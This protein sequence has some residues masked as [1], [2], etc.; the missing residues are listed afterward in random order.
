MCTSRARK[1]GIGGCRVQ[2]PCSKR[3]VVRGESPGAFRGCRL[4]SAAAAGTPA[5]HDD[6]FSHYG[7][8]T[9]ATVESVETGLRG[10][11]PQAAG[12]PTCSALSTER[13]RRWRGKEGLRYGPSSRC[14]RVLPRA[15]RRQLSLKYKHSQQDQVVNSL[16]LLLGSS[17]VLMVGSLAGRYATPEMQ[18]VHDLTVELINA[19]G[20]GAVD[21]GL[22]PALKPGGISQGDDALR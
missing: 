9:P 16:I 2:G 15:T 13:V 21:V 11:S 20:D 6:K 5:A 10:T 18:S 4:F 7:V 1:G 22:S 12:V 17:V 8:E 19:Y 14:R 3:A